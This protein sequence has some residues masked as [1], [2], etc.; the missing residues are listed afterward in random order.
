MNYCCCIR[1]V[2]DIKASFTPTTICVAKISQVW[3]HLLFTLCRAEWKRER[4]RE[5]ERENISKVDFVVV[6]NEPQA[7]N[8][9]KKE[10]LAQVFSCEFCEISKNTFFT[11]PLWWLLLLWTALTDP[12]KPNKI[13]FS[14]LIYKLNIW[15]KVFNNRRS[16]IIEDS[17]CLIE[18]SLWK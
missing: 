1:Q 3:S 11:E 15:D 2:F 5:R 9:I 7:C 14:C 12:H 6:V 18:D 13:P 17:L 16:K 10:T 8:F 4:K